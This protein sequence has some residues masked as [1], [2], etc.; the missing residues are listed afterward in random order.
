MRALILGH[1]L[2]PT[3]NAVAAALVQRGGWQVQ[4][5][6]IA[7]LAKARWHQQLAADGR[8]ATR[9]D[10][11]AGDIGACDVVFNRLGSAQALAFPGWSPANRD[12]GQAEWLALLVSW[13]MG[14]GDR[15][16]GAPAGSALC[17]PSNRPWLWMAAAA[18]AGLAVH[19]GG[20]TT[21]S[22]QFPPPRG[23]AERPELLAA[24]AGAGFVPDRPSGY[25]DVAVAQCEL[26]L[27]GDAVFGGVDPGADVRAATLAL[28]AAQRTPLL[29][30]T[31][32]QRAG[33][34]GWR[35]VAAD[36]APMV[37]EGAPLDALIALMQARAA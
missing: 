25:A 12:Y 15:V 22:R 17:G 2:D 29:A 35:F 10:A 37:A 23:S 8:I 5:H 21:S 16:I 20:A 11:G 19:P 31:L 36:A 24:A 18:A 26:L 13:L 30:L 33:D 1:A 32:A 4:R 34:P 14:L 9:I 3:A 6:D 28:A 27:V 7:A